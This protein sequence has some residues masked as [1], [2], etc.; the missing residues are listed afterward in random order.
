MAAAIDIASREL[1]AQGNE[2]RANEGL[3]H[4]RIIEID[5]RPAWDVHWTSP[6]AE[7]GGPVSNVLIDARSGRVLSCRTEGTC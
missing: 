1:A 6:E 2:A 5:R 3:W 4:A 7:A